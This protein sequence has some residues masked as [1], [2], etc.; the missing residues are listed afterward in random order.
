MQ[1]N[2]HRLSVQL[3]LRLSLPLVKEIILRLAEK[4]HSNNFH[5]HIYTTLVALEVECTVEGEYTH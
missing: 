3:V 2:T 1:I 5:V 4:T